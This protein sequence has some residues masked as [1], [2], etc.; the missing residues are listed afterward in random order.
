MCFVGTV[1]SILCIATKHAPNYPAHNKD[2]QKEPHNKTGAKVKTQAE[3]IHLS[4]HFP[5]CIQGW[6]ASDNTEMRT[7]IEELGGWSRV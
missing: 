7:F 6:G 4:S 2:L 3:D 5:M 1:E